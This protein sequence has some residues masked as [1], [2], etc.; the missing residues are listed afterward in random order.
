M[1]KPYLIG[2]YHKINKYLKTGNPDGTRKFNLLM[3]QYLFKNK[4][5]NLANQSGSNQIIFNTATYLSPDLIQRLKNGYV[6]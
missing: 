1:V 3:D 5:T 6:S 2:N 4:T